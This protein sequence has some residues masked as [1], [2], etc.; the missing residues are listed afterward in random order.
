[1]AH[2]WGKGLF[3]KP[4]AETRYRV[5]QNSVTTEI[6]LTRTDVIPIVLSRRAGNVHRPGQLPVYVHEQ[7][8]GMVFEKEEKIATTQTW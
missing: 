4:D 3:V 2:V 6:K 1:M 7:C 5:P 8:A